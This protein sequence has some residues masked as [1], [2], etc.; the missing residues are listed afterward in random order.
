MQA[1]RNR[2]GPISTFK[3]GQEYSV[4]ASGHQS[5]EA[6]LSHTQWEFSQVVAVAHHI[7]CVKLYLVI[8]LSAVQ[9]VEVRSAVHTK[10][11]GF[12]IKDEGGNADA[13]RGFND[14]RVSITPVVAVAREQPNALAFTVNRKAVAVV[15]DFVDPIRPRRYRCSAGRQIRGKLYSTHAG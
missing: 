12:T 3:I 2:S 6:C 8:M 10:Q 1:W 7:E 14:Q 15:F 5:R 11:H 4:D 13:K 9:P